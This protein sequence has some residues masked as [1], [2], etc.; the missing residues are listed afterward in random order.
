VRNRG[1]TDADIDSQ[2]EVTEE[3]GIPADVSVNE[4]RKYVFHRKL[5]GIALLHGRLK[6][7]TAHAAKPAT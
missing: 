4:T 3:F 2:S 1:G 5:R 6:S 7:F